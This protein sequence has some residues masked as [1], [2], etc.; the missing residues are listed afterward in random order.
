MDGLKPV[1]E[2]D[3]REVEHEIAQRYIGFARR[4][5]GIT[6][7]ETGRL[8]ALWRRADYLYGRES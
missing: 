1:G 4:N 3:L 6:L 5:P 2:M 7:P 8:G